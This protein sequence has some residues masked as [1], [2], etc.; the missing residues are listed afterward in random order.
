M[1]HADKC[2]CVALD[3]AIRPVDFQPKVKMNNHLFLCTV[4][5]SSDTNGG[6]MH[7]MHIAEVRG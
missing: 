2:I 4:S 3:L 7:L 6:H 1:S 5:L